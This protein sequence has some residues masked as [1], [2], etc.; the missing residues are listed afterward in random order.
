MTHRARSTQ[1]S[2]LPNSSS[3]FRVHLC[4]FCC[5]QCVCTILFNIVLW[6][7]FVPCQC[8]DKAQELSAAYMQTAFLF[9]FLLL[10]ISDRDTE[11]ANNRRGYCIWASSPSNGGKKLHLEMALSRAFVQ[12]EQVLSAVPAPPGF[13]W[14]SKQSSTQTSAWDGPRFYASLIKGGRNHG[15]TSCFL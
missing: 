12:F 3:F 7:A 9:H 14:W 4:S 11:A 2:L 10:Q 13:Q 5:A 15:F 8:A 6:L 1:K